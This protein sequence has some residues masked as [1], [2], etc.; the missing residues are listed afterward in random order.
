M[1]TAK[2]PG[3]IGWILVATL[4]IF[5]LFLLCVFVANLL[6]ADANVKASI[7]GLLGIVSAA[8][9]THYK[10]KEREISARHFANKREGYTELINLIFDLLQSVK[11]KQNM[12]QE[13]LV[14]K[15][16]FFKKSLMIWG[17]P[18]VIRAWNAYELKSQA[19]LSR[20]ETL[21]EFDILLKTIREDLGH[22]D[23]T[24]PSGNLTALI[25]DPK[26]KQMVLGKK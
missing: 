2:L 11:N 25:L 15:M 4:T 13:E 6:K 20:E 5:T 12:Q 16:M 8:L 21:Q 18:E 17:G 26:A 22:D 24:L 7:I 10:T 3:I 14:K 19:Q 23:R 1:N 9:V